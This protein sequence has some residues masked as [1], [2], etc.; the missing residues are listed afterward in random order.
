MCN[1][2]Q[3]LRILGININDISIMTVE[4]VDFYCIIHSSEVINLLRNSVLEDLDICK[5][6]L[7]SA[8]VYIYKMI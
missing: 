4:N 3:D 6:I 7:S 8:S 1:G 2:C 5:K